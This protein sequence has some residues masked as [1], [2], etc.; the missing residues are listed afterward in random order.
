VL[1]EY[2]LNKLKEKMQLQA[3]QQASIKDTFFLKI[4]IVFIM[5]YTVDAFILV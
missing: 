4:G 5:T 1:Q 3:C 2:P